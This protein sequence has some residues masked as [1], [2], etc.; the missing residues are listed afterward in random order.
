MQAI[1]AGL[2]LAGLKREE[3][4]VLLG[5]N[6]PRLYAAMLAAQSL[7]AIPMPLYQ[8]AVAPECVFPINNA[9]IRFCIVEDQEQVDKLLEVREQCPQLA[10]IWYDEPRGLRDYDHGKLHDI[11]AVIEAGR[12]K[13][14]DSAASAALDAEMAQGSGSDLA[15]ILYTS[16]TTGRP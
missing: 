10:R 4:L 7:G 9:D 13:L 5:S 16:G 3:H 11:S 8:D 2:H 6:R 15:I 12:A 1:A 14:K